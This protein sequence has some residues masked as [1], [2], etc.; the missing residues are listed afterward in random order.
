M[1]VPIELGFKQTA[2]Q[3]RK[4]KVAVAE[5]VARVLNRQRVIENVFQHVV[6]ETPRAIT[7]RSVS[8]VIVE[9]CGEDV[10]Q[11]ISIAFTILL[12]TFDAEP[13]F[14]LQKVEEDNLP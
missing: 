12:V 1:F 11:K 14:A 8:P 6:K 3:K 13:A 4:P 5:N 7:K 2:V 10:R 9:A